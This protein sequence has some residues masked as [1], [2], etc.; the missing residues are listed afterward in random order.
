MHWTSHWELV[1]APGDQLLTSIVQET[2]NY[3]KQLTHVM[4]YF[5]KEEDPG[6]ALPKNFIGGFLEVCP[7]AVAISLS[8]DTKYRDE[9]R[10]IAS[11][12][13]MQYCT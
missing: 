13:R 11:K 5:R 7:Q 8:I 9:I 12:A 6:A 2:L 10:P 4:K 1:R 3:W